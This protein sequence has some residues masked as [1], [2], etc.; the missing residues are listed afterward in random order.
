MPIPFTCP[1]CGATTDADDHFAGQSGP[2][3]HCGKMVTVPST[4]VARNSS[5]RETPGH[6]RP[7]GGLIGIIA[8]LVIGAVMAMLFMSALSAHHHAAYRR[9]QS[10]NN[11]K[12]IVLA[13]LN[14]ET[15]HRTLPPAYIADENGRPMHSW[16]V[17]ILPYLDEQGLYDQYRFDEP[18]DG[19]HNRLMQERMPAVFADP[20]SDEEPNIC[21]NY[22]VI[23]GE[24]TMFPGAT[25]IKLRD[26]LDGPS[27]VIAVAS[28]GES[29]IIWTEPRDLEFDRMSFK[30]ND[31][32]FPGI[33]DVS[34]EDA[35]VVFGDGR[36]RGLKPGT[37]E[38]EIKSLILRNDG[39]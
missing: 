27:D 17:L 33:K 24:G 11:L 5:A 9:A 29:D 34:L 8:I 23:T 32:D 21:T 36:A 2:C 6:F 16:R 14:Y 25:A 35:P 19:P 22:A 10:L 39:K 3:S 12:Q 38:D 18:W 13:L 7:A 20:R 28:I 4:S 31:P 1:H 15:V 26:I 30:I 37:P